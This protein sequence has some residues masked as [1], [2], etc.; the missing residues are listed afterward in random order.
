MQNAKFEMR[1]DAQDLPNWQNFAFHIFHF[2][3]PQDAEKPGKKVV[4]R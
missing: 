2:F 4:L 1:N 3:I